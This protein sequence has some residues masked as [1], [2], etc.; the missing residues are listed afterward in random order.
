[1]ISL[2][3]KVFSGHLRRARPSTSA[4]SYTRGTA[5]AAQTADW[6]PEPK[7]L[8]SNLAAAPTSERGAGASRPDPAGG[9]AGSE[10]PALRK[11]MAG[12]SGPG[13]YTNL[14]NANFKGPDSNFKPTST[15]SGVQFAIPGAL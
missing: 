7:P 2:N 5:E 15:E 4:P 13:S 12:A 9:A 8:E 11:R 3:G 6:I 1:M 14:P 10:S